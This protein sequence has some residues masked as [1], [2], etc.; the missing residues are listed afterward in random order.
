MGL[1]F[2]PRTVLPSTAI[3]SRPSACTARVK[4]AALKY[5]THLRTPTG[6]TATDSAFKSLAAVYAKHGAIAAW[7]PNA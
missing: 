3:T 6:G 5:G 7:P 1:S 4:G 2:A